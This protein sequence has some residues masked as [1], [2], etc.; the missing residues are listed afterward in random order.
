MNFFLTLCFLGLPPGGGNLMIPS[1]GP[2]YPSQVQTIGLSLNAQSSPNP[3]DLQ[4]MTTGGTRSVTIGHPEMTLNMS[5][6]HV[7]SDSHSPYSN[8][9]SQSQS[10]H[11]PST[12]TFK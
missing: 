4:D 6:P 5:R 11:L 9:P 12:A 1:N 3:A 8:S 7:T 2:L 10:P